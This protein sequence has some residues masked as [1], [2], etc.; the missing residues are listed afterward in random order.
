VL[1]LSKKRNIGVRGGQKIDRRW[2]RPEYIYCS[3]IDQ[4]SHKSSSSVLFPHIPRG[5][6]SFADETGCPSASGTETFILGLRKDPCLFSAFPVMRVFSEQ[7]I[8]LCCFWNK[9]PVWGHLYP[10]IECPDI[11]VIEMS[12]NFFFGFKTFLLVVSS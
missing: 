1:L 2:S 11:F 5:Q 12:P 9:F 7:K 10:V 8:I 4:S 6:P 3:Q